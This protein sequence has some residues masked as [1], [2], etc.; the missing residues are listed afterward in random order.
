MPRTFGDD[1]RVAAEDNRHVM[2]PTGEPSALV[3]IEPISG[4]TSSS[5][6]TDVPVFTWLARRT[7]MVGFTS[8]LLPWRIQGLS[9]HETTVG[10][11]G[12]PLCTH[13]G[14]A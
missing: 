1:E 8:G 4:H 6:G 9:N 11:F 13:A 2:M 3:V 10:E 14:I 5:F 12:F 7:S